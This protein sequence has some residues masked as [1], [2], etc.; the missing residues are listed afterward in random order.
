MHTYDAF[1]ALIAR[2]RSTPNEYLYAGERFDPEAG[3]YHLRARQ[4]NP[5]RGRFWS[6]DS[7]EGGNGDPRT[8]H[9]F[10]YAAA[11]PVNK[12]DPSGYS[13]IAT[14]MGAMQARTSDRATPGERRSPDFGL[15][16]C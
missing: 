5:Q 13:F 9:R 4:M 1:G 11:D 3:L 14:E 10:L 15:P 12:A 6:M 7:H 16:H 2:A 8:L